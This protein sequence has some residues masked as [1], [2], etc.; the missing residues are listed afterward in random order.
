MPTMNTPSNKSEC[1]FREKGS[2]Q[3]RLFP[4]C[5]FAAVQRS[6]QAAILPT[7]API[8]TIALMRLSIVAVSGLLI[9]LMW[10][11]MP[12]SFSAIRFARPIRTGCHQI[13]S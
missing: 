11:E 5:Q 9:I 12:V 13:S 10:D 3:N 8:E 2:P 6:R 7:E 4:K 1:S